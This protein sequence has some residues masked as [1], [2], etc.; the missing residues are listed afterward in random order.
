LNFKTL[1]TALSA[2]A[3][4]GI[5]VRSC[6]RLANDPQSFEITLVV[7]TFG[8][9]IGWLLG[10]VLS[11]YT[12]DEKAR[13]TDYAKAFG[14]LV[15]GYLAGKIDPLFSRLLEPGFVFD[16]KRGIRVIAFLTSLLLSLIVTFVFR[17]YANKEDKKTIE[18]RGAT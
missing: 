15:S 3:L 12:P 14:V 17:A 16:P 11:P 18:S 4:A 7:I 8:A 1:L 13:F 6:Y 9:S 2:L 5:L 10:F